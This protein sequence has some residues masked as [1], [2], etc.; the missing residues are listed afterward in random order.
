M[1]SNPKLYEINTRVWIKQFGKDIKLSE[2][3]V[4]Y[5]ENLKRKGFD[6]IWL[7]GVWKI[8]EENI[9]YALSPDLIKTYKKCLHDWK[10]E[11]VIGSP[12]A[13]DSYQLNPSLGNFDDILILKTKLNSIGLKL[14]LDFI[15]NHFGAD[16]SVVKSFPHLFLQGNEQ[17]LKENPTSYFRSNT[18]GKIIL[19]HG[20]DP[21]FPAWS[22]TAQVNYFSEQT[23][24]YMIEQLIQLTGYCDG[25]R[26]DMAMLPMNNIFQN[27]WPGPIN[28]FNLKK[29]KTEFWY[30]AIKQVK[31]VKPNFTLIAEVYWDLEAEL[32]DLGFDYTYCKHYLDMFINNDVFGI[33]NNLKSDFNYL[34]KLVL[35]LENHD[36]DR[37]VTALGSNKSMAAVVSF[38]TMPGMKLIYDGQLEGKKIKYP[39]QLGR[40][41]VE[42][43]SKTIKDFYTKILS[44]V[45]NDV[46]NKGKFF[47]LQ[48]GIFN[49]QDESNKNILA[50]YWHYK[51][52]IKITVVNYSSRHSKCKIK[53]PCNSLPEKVVLKDMLTKANLR[54]TSKKLNDKGFVVQLKGYQSRIIEI[55]LMKVIG[56]NVHQ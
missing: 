27:T 4:E 20:K 39:V 2:I 5:F 7:M 42:K 18:K 37:A 45:S 16:S 47:V 25:V 56:K 21:F 24:K 33:T 32:Q 34:K 41:S 3:P 46:Y 10:P 26:C 8:P 55:D 53:I 49:E 54:M 52:E 12:Y 30:D 9:K 15:P 35:F 22:D 38:L 6:Y 51:N 44:I 1:N 36:E 50:W 48:P 29:P 13:I 17:L 43:G 11:D 28:K 14:I 40:T 31:K 19:A 23:R